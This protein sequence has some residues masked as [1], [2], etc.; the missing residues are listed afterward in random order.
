MVAAFD[1][2]LHGKGGA[3]PVDRHRDARPRR[4]GAR[5]PPAP[6]LGH[7]D[8]D[9]RRTARSSRRRSSATRSCGCRGA[10]PASSSAS[11]S[12]RSRRRTPRRSAA[13]SA[14]TASPRGATPPR[15]PRRTRS[16]SSRPPQA[17]IDEHGKHRPV[18]RGARRSTRRSSRAE[19]RAKAAALARDDPRH[20]LARQADGRP[21]H[22]RPPRCSTSSRRASTRSSP[23]SARA[24]PTTSCAPR[25][26]RC[27]STCPPTR[28]IEELDRAA[29][30]AARG[31]P[32]RLH[33]RTTTPHATAE[34]PRDPRR[35]PAHRARARRRHV[36]LRREQADRARRRRV[37]PQRDQRDARRRGA[38]DLLPD[39]AT[40]RSSASSTGR[41][42]R[43]SCSGCRSRRPTRAASRSSRARHPASARPS[44][45]ASPPRARA[46]S[47]PTSTSRRRR[48]PRPSSAAR[49]S[50]SASPRTS[51][52]P[53]ACRPRSTRRVLA[54]G[55]IDLVV[56]NA[57]LSLSKPLLE[58]TEKDW[59]L[60][61]DV[62][63]KGSFLVSKAAA[64]VLIEQGL[65]GD[66]IYI[67]SKNSVFA[68]PNNIAYSAT[69]A[70]Q[71]HQV[72]LLAVELGEYGVQGQR[73]QPRRRRARL[74]HL[75][76]PAGARTAPRPTASRRRTSASSTPSARS[77]SARSS[78]RTSRRR[79]SCSPDPS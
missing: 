35:R 4:R 26:S 42:K 24:A 64:K 18:R 15:R 61:H 23:R 1:Y 36:Q 21:L 8:R 10:A 77:S 51:P 62:M 31:L 5:R 9:G 27:C 53:T 67:S 30:G 49:M 46:S 20:R 11:T 60:Q 74:G 68:G 16:G 38:L 73:H 19:R 32:R 28:P 52:M 63:A 41:S 37:L 48:P 14:A 66:I 58:T 70:D 25:S 44:R 65:G 55:G 47:S 6:R 43:P 76:E 57:G 12:P 22:R 56:N 2:C 13:S 34:S 33:R 3:A 17:Y 45:P 29:E 78:P 69:K 40:P 71:A 39:L 7:R 75:R 54:F 79:V 59:D 72:R 50:R